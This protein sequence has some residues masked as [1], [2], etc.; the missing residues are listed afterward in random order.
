MPEFYT[1]VT[2]LLLP[3]DKKDTWVGMKTLGELKRER[4]IKNEVHFFL[5][6]YYVSITIPVVPVFDKIVPSE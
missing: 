4:N 1:T 5:L 2:S 6:L 3:K